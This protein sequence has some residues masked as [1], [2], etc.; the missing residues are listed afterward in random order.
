MLGYAGGYKL[1]VQVVPHELSDR[2]YSAFTGDCDY[3]ASA[4]AE[5][6]LFRVI[7]GRGN[8]PGNPQ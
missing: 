5:L 2:R 7:G 1:S 6:P 4:M 8:R 3:T